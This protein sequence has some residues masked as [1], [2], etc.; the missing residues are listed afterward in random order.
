MERYVCIHGHFYQPPRENPWL[1]AIELQDS[2]YPYHDWNE[3]ITTECYE[4]NA[5]SRILDTENR[6]VGIVDNYAKISFNFGPTLLAWMEYSAPAVYQAVL[7]A[8]KRSQDAFSGHG[9][10]LAQPYNH[11]IMPLANQRDKYTQVLWGI[12]DFEHRFGRKPE[13]M[14]LPETAVDFE[15][16]DIMAELGL[17]FTIL[18]P[19]Q[20]S[21]VRRIGETAWHDVSQ[22]T[23]DPTT[24]YELH[25]PS[26]RK[27]ALFFYHGA[28]ARAVAFEGLL[29][30][31]ENVASRLV[32]AF[33]DQEDWPQL[34]H[35]ATDGETYGHHHR[36]GDM[37]LAYALHYIESNN[38][39]RL[40]N[41][42]EYLEKHPPTHEVEVFENT[43]WSCAHG[44]E[45]WRGDCGC[46]TGQHP[47]WN[48]AWRAPLREALDWLRDTLAP[49]YAD[50]AS[51]L[52]KN[53]WVARDQYIDVILDRSADSIERFLAQHAARAIDQ[54]E[55]TTVLKLLELQRHAMLMFTSC[56]WFFE[57]LSGIETVQVMQYAG[58]AL[59]L[60]QEVLGD[61]VEP[62]FLEIL[63]KAK[64]NI[65]QHLDGR[66]IYEK[67]VR[68]AMVELTKVAA[69]YVISSLF[70]EYGEAPSIFCFRVSVGDY[71]LFE[72]GRAKLAVGRANFTSEITG[73]SAALSFGVLHFGD[74]NLNA[75]VREYQGEASYKLMLQEVSDAF[76]VADF[77][78]V[79]RLMDRHFGTSAYTARSLF[80]D[81]QRK[82][83]EYIL[84]PTLA[85]VEAM[86]RTIYEQHCPLMR[87][88]ADLGTPLPRALQSAA[89]LILNLDLRRA[90]E[91]EV[92]DVD[93]IQALLE[94]VEV[95][96]I[97]IDTPG[98]SHAL[99]DTLGRVAEQFRVEPEN[100]QALQ[101]FDGVVDIA[102]S[103]PFEVEYRKAQ[104]VY[105]DVLQTTYPQVRE[106]AELGNR[107]ARSWL[108]C[109]K[110]L[111]ERLLVRVD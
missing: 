71:Q 37:A 5:T 93:G 17:R 108:D 51:Q 9:S 111:G 31:G 76:A 14:W 50:G 69:H 104:N 11:M 107:E 3:R 52:L 8:D 92:L 95:W 110:A 47:R 109:F 68:P 22:G 48:Q 38:L 56:G 81:E 32:E 62:R 19:G 23:I 60:A 61:D 33:S 43:S 85:D 66:Y 73:E 27:I 77:P 18:A 70:E 4:P 80:R 79:I 24:A 86:H 45:R 6:I 84:A 53:P 96:Q 49:M 54:A 64:S 102:R 20:A 99:E 39:A 100:V 94:A 26:G 15:T 44:I 97:E 29:T 2:A 98:L 82:V 106:K 7:D 83:L 13:G 101:S 42:G 41:Y 34:V 65:R 10:S 16:L 88:L 91:A 28:I 40:T 87:F 75:G 35:I 67:F 55:T 63:E 57:E 25:L 46:T 21:R 90:F 1:E 59:Q 58:R 74:H 89:E 12:R 36:Y 103:V 30:S 105:Y 78:E 72:V